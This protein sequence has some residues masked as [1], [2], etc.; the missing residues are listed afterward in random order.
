[1][2]ASGF[3][4]P[5]H[6]TS[7]KSTDKQHGINRGI[8]LRAGGGGREARWLGGLGWGRL[9]HGVQQGG[10]ELEKAARGGSSAAESG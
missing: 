1:M 9:N 10:S 5:G 3:S 7:G 4:P 6:A 8:A 2:L